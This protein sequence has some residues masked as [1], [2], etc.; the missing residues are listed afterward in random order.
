[1]NSS[2]MLKLPPQNLEAEESV[3]GALMIDK[4]AIIRVAD[5][6]TPADFYTPSHGKIY[7]A[8]LKLFSNHKP[9]DILSLTAELK[10][11]NLLQE[12]GGSTYLTQLVNA[13]PTSAHI[14]HYAKIVR[15]KK[16]L[17]D[18]IKTSAE[19]TEHAMGP[20]EDMEHILDEI[21][22]RIFGISQ[23][24]IIQKFVAVKDELQSAYERIE[25]L[26]RGEGTLRG[27]PTG[28]TQLDNILSGLQRSDM[29]V[30]G[31]R[32]SLGKTSLALD[33]A[34]HMAIKEQKSVGVFSLE[35]SREQVIDR[36]ISAEAR[37][38]LWKLR[39]GKISQ[40]SDFELIQHALDVLSRAPLYIDDSASPNILQMRS[41]ARRL[42]IEHGLDVLIIDYLQLIMPRTGNENMV[43]Q[44][45]EISRGIKGLSRELNIP[46]IAI[47]QLSR[48]VD[49]RE[50]KMPRLSDLRESGCLTGDAKIVRADTGEVL[51]LQSLAERPIQSPIPVFTLD[52]Q[53]KTTVRPLIKAWRTGKKQTYALRL[54]SGRTIRGSSNHPFRKL[55]DW[56]RLDALKPG[57]RIALPRKLQTTLPQNL[58]QNDELILLAHLLGDGCTVPRQPIHYTSGDY[59]NILTVQGT[60]KRLFGITSRIVPQENWWHIYLPSPHHLTHGKPHPITAWFRKMGIDL[61][62]AHEKVIPASVFSSDPSR[63]ALFLKHLWA[64]DG[65][66]SWKRLLGR[67]PGA[68]IYYSSTSR[69]LAS[70]VQHLLLRLGIQSTLRM[71][72]Q[73]KHRPSYQTWIQDAPNQLMFLHAIGSAGARGAIVPELIHALEQIETNPNTDVIPQEAWK[74]AVTPAKV[75]AGMGWREVSA[76]LHMSYCGSSLFKTGIGRERMS[77][78]ASVLPDFTLEH[79][80][81]SDVFWD[82]VIKIVPGGIEEVFDAT[83]EGTHNFVANDIFV[84]NSIEQ[85]SDVVMFIYRKDRGESRVSP[86]EENVAEILV[87]KHRNGPLGTVKL[88]F[89]P[90]LASFETID[91]QHGASEPF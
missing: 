18:L 68:H 67:K 9:I 25:R 46:I 49:Q 63:I 72:P 57:D 89:N 80:A 31:A 81:T 90:D 12:I 38:P 65:N 77:R 40:E 83:I 64:T 17:R 15:D 16:I 78:L 66:I 50:Q 27:I 35:M 33:M 60:A 51:T 13:V 28:F 34:R 14:A 43:Q 54:R 55:E 61:Y 39:T 45:T 10:D 85:D 53:W 87:A 3:L 82:E 47:S 84:H 11:M 22:Q 8:I 5:I 32:P 70:Q 44:V 71:V 62:H 37:V 36:L 19:I 24:S 91:R 4:E 23:Q 69:I 86:E 74:Y 1:M 52:E 20:V 59:E 21:E 42:Q 29:V 48:A 41:M 75:A 76:G 58:L 6:L 26:H 2:T 79:L 30:I 56:S 73:E 7:E 88:R